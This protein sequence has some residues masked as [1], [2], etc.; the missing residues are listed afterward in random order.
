MPLYL[1]VA[2]YKRVIFAGL[3]KSP[4]NFHFQRETLELFNIHT[5]GTGLREL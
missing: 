2:T 1:E 5:E 4:T 3:S